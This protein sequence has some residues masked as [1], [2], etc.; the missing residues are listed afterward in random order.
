MKEIFKIIKNNNKKIFLFFL[1]ILIIFIFT[2]KK[3]NSFYAVQYGGRIIY[4]VPP[5]VCA[6]P[7]PGVC[8]SACV[9]CGCGLWFQVVI[10]PA[11]GSGFY[12]CPSFTASKGN[13]P[14]Y[15]PG[16]S[17]MTGGSSPYSLDPTNTAA[18]VKENKF[19]GNLM[20]VWFKI[21]TIFL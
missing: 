3:L 7:M 17:V 14:M 4:S 1:L 19:K 12:F 18:I 10:Q 6:N 21:K 16:G 9:L 13:N 5:S 15:M 11:G 8:S 20:L 2:I